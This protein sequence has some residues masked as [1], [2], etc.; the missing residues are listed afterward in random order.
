M[1]IASI[2]RRLLDMRGAVERERRLPGLSG[3]DGV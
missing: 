1:K 3:A 2:R